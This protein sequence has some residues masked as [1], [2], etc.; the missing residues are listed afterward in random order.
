MKFDNVNI[1]DMLG[2]KNIILDGEYDKEELSQFLIDNWVSYIDCDRKC[3]RADYCPFTKAIPYDTSRHNDIKCGVI[4]NFIRNFIESTYAI[5]IKIDPKDYSHYFNGLFFLSNFVLSTEILIGLSISKENVDWYGDASPFLFS[6]ILKLRDELNKAVIELK[7]IERL[8]T[9]SSILFVEGWTEKQL[10][11]RLKQT[12]STW[13]TNLNIIV[14]G[15]SANIR[16]G[17][18][19]MILDDYSRRGYNI[20]IQGDLDGNNTDKF[21]DL[22]QKCNIPDSNIFSFRHDL[23]TSIPLVI[24]HNILQNIFVAFEN[25]DY[26]D[27]KHKL[28]EDT[29]ETSILKKVNDIFEID[30]SDAKMNIANFLGEILSDPYFSWWMDD[31]FM[32][33]E[34][35]MFLEFIM[36]IH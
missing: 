9:K 2:T 8:H 26:E 19:K 7:D 22:K 32:K 18:A 25:V 15:G 10:L 30:I 24:L 36:R 16:P 5:L 20:Y 11:E 4:V 1:L 12:N 21:Q 33:T 27:F 35:G 3:A 17:R 29:R 34:I 28:L 6:G 31:N 13:F 14:Y 23:E